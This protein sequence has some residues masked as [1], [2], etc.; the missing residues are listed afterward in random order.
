MAV[1]LVVIILI[2][3][4]SLYEYFSAKNWQQVTSH[5]RNEVIFEG[6]NQEYGAYA[7][8]RDYDKKII[9]ILLGLVLVI[10]ITFGIAKYVRSKIC[11]CRYWS[12]NE[13]LRKIKENHG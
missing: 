3:F 6:K 11:L 10:G 9:Y 12:W 4:V 7:L 8:R 5:E 13:L 2:S 1:T